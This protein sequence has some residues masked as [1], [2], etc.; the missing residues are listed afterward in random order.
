[1]KRLNFIWNTKISIGYTPCYV[2]VASRG[3]SSRRPTRS[4]LA[5][6]GGACYD[7]ITLSIRSVADI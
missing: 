7:N 4:K 5:A 6:I 3:A 1:M 2:F